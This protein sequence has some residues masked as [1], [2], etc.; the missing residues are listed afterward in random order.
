MGVICRVELTF[1]LFISVLRILKTVSC[2]LL[3]QCPRPR[4]LEKLHQSV[5]ILKICESWMR[6]HCHDSR[7]QNLC[8][9]S[10]FS[11]WGCCRVCPPSQGTASS[12]LWPICSTWSSS[13]RGLP[14]PPT[15]LAAPDKLFW[16]SWHICFWM[17]VRRHR[18]ASQRFPSRASHLPWLHLGS[19]RGEV[20]RFPSH[21]WASTGGVWAKGDGVG[22]PVHFC[23]KLF[24]PVQNCSFLFDPVQIYLI[25]WKCNPSP[26]SEMS[27]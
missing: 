11:S 27:P 22:A 6:P 5:M 3:G 15:N 24:D 16:K 10:Q 26:P 7:L 13:P 9:A 17:M 4:G 20:S 19:A 8:Q 18:H 2:Q 14:G 1:D 23:S 12:L 21:L 25:E